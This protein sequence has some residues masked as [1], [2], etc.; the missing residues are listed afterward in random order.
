MSIYNF[1]TCLHFAIINCRSAF[2]T[3]KMSQTLLL[4]VTMNTSG[5]DFIPL[6]QNKQLEKTSV[7]P[8]LIKRHEYIPRITEH[9]EMLNSCASNECPVYDVSHN[10]IMT[11]YGDILFPYFDNIASNSSYEFYSNE[12]IHYDR[13]NNSEITF[14]KYFVQTQNYFRYNNGNEIA[15]PIKKQWTHKNLNYNYYVYC[16]TMSFKDEESFDKELP[17][18]GFDEKFFLEMILM[19]KNLQIK[20][21]KA[22]L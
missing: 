5:N 9:I 15:L 19:K 6:D 8:I 1:I 20:N 10:C 17:S 21:L 14:F 12:I 2:S 22:W 13:Y 3:T 7:G 16:P 18:G 11:H 4:L